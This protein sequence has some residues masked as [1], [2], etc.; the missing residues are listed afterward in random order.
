MIIT[1]IIPLIL[2]LCYKILLLI[3]TFFSAFPSISGQICG[4]HCCNNR[5]E[6]EILGKSI[7]L[8]EGL[9]RQHT[10]KIKGLWEQTTS[11]YKGEFTFY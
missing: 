8:F 1:A 3:K 11:L 9:I 7:N 4:G 2:M 10:K 5:T 6:E